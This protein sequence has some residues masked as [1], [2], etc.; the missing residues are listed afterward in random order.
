M[1]K[2]L[3]LRSLGIRLFYLNFLFFIFISCFLFLFYFFFFLIFF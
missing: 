1:G 3:G 2:E